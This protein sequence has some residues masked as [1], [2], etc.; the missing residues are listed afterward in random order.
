MSGGTRRAQGLRDARMEHIETR[1][2]PRVK[3]VYLD[4]V[5]LA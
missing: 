4:I 2:R 1:M 3:P 5:W